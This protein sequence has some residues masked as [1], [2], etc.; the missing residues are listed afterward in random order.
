LAK[1]NRLTAHCL[2][3]GIPLTF[4]SNN[5]HV[6][7]AVNKLLEYFLCE[8]PLSTPPEGLTI[9]FFDKPDDIAHQ[10]IIPSGLKLLYSSSEEDLFDIKEF[11]I[12]KMSL[13]V[14]EDDF[15]YYV[16][17]GTI[18]LFSY[19]MKKGVAEGYLKGP[20]AI[21]PN[22]ISSFIFIFLLAELLK[23][24][25]YFL[26]HCSGVEKKG[27][28]I[29]FPGFSGAGKTTSCV[30][31]IRQGFGFLGDDR[32]ILRYNKSGGLELLSFPEPI[33]VTDYTIQL[34]PELRSYRLFLDNRN[35]R[36]QSFNAEDLYPGS[37]R[38]SC[39]PKLILFPEISAVKKSSLEIFPKSEALKTFLPHSLLAF[40]K[41]TARQHFDIIFDLIQSTDCYKIKLGADIQSLPDL[42]ESIF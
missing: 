3:H 1:K 33:D 20:E 41:E 9:T 6:F 5:L 11:G 34:F 29:I 18:G 27:Q 38:A 4:I 21:N 16:A 32:P 17:F 23:G 24:K 36:K 13:Y 12:D 14:N 28:G 25:G 30:A 10:G 31:L 39:V 42:V 35:L 19:S 15:T 22:L 40:D 8:K 7:S 2:I 26:A 37:T